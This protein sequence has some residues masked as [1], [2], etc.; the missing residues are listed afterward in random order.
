[1]SASLQLRSPSV[2]PESDTWRQA[3][4][5]AA[6]RRMMQVSSGTFSLSFAVCQ[7]P[8]LRTSLINRLCGEFPGTLI[9]TLTEMVDDVLSCVQSQLPAP[10][11]EAIF[12][13][14]LESSIPF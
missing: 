1:M 14:G 10:P 2:A 13:V 9:V 3:A 7:D 8:A 4:D 11:P 12:I 5:L 6:F